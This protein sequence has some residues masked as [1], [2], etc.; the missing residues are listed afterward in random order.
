[1]KLVEFFE[2]LGKN[3]VDV[4]GGKGANL[5]ELTNAGITVPHGFVLTAKTYDKF[6]KETGIFDE[7]MGILDA[8]DVNDTKELQGASARIK[9]III[10]AYVPDDIRTTIIEAYNA[11]CQRIGKEDAFVAIRSSATAEDLPEASFGHLYLNPELYFT[12]KKIIL[13]IPKFILLLLFRKW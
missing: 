12:G 2:E 1:M 9:K 11:L 10:D 4:A 7:I 5:G 8:I 6:I 3:D 13:I